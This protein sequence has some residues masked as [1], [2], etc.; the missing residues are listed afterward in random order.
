MSQTRAPRRRR[1]FTPQD[2]DRMLPL[3]RAIV[4]DVVETAA[5]VKAR[6]RELG[7]RQ[8]SAEQR[9]RTEAELVV[10]QERFEQLHQEL[11]DLG[12]ELK[13][14]E[15]GLIDFPALHEGRRVLICWHLGE[16]RIGYW[17]ELTTGFAG[18]RP[19]ALLRQSSGGGTAAPTT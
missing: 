10:L 5:E 7:R 3:V 17:H 9:E 13:D 4:R 16:E 12:I 6:A 11:H 8:V 19:I 14:T 15:R 2:A 1:I 18:R